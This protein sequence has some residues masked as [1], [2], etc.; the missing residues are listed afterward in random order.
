VSNVA[1]IAE[2]GT[3]T[4]PI[5][6]PTAHAVLDTV[7]ALYDATEV[8]G[9]CA[10]GLAS[11]AAAAVDRGIDTTD[12]CCGQLWVRI[13]DVYPSRRFPEPDAFPADAEDLAWAVMVEVG[14]VRPAT[15]VTEIDGQ[16]VLPSMQEE[17]DAAERTLIDA[18][19]LRQ[20]LLVTY[21]EQFDVTVLLGRW[22]PL[23]PEG[24]VVGGAYTATIQV[25]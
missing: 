9:P 5:G 15:M 14:I 20:A 11:G 18:A 19:L 3:V 7:L 21:A 16:P 8:Q 2:D 6:I 23:G 10:A 4:D 13:A 1:C 24:G 22:V 12:D 17:T 25:L